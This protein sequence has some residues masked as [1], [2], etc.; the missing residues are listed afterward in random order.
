MAERQ[1]KEISD[2]KMYHAEYV[3]KLQARQAAEMEELRRT[4]EEEREGALTKERQLASSRQG[5]CIILK[6]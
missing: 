5:L 2:L 3:G 6:F 1:H 4:L